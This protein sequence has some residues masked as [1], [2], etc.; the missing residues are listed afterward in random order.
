M[1]NLKESL[2]LEQLFL[3]VCRRGDK[4][5][6][7]AALEK[8]SLFDVNCVDAD[9]KSALVIAVESAQTDVVELLA[10]HPAIKH[11][12]ALLRAVDNH[13]LPEVKVLCESLKHRNLLLSGLYC[14]ASNSDFHPYVTPV[15]LAAHYNNYDILKLLTIEYGARVPNPSDLASPKDESTL[16]HSVGSLQLYKA[17]T[18]EVYMSLTQED[19]IEYAFKLCHKMRQLSMLNF[20]FRFEYEEFADKCETYAADI[21]GSVQ[22]TEEQTV[23]LTHQS[24]YS[25]SGSINGHNMTTDDELVVPYKVKRAIDYDQKK[26]VAHAHCQHRLVE[27]WYKGL[28]NWRNQ[29]SMK[30]LIFSLIMMFFYPV[31]SICYIL[32]PSARPGNLLKIPYVKFLCSVAS[33]LTFLLLLCLQSFQLRYT[34][35]ELFLI[36][37]SDEKPVTT[38]AEQFLFS[39]V[40]IQIVLFIVA[41]TWK[42]IRELQV[43][44]YRVLKYN[45]QGKLYDYFNLTLYWVWLMLR[46]SLVIQIYLGKPDTSSVLGERNNDTTVSEFDVGTCPTTW[47]SED[48]SCL[49]SKL[50][51]VMQQQENLNTNITAVIKDLEEKLQLQGGGDD[52][53]TVARRRK[54]SNVAA[55]LMGS[56]AS[57]DHSP[58]FELT[59]LQQFSV[60]QTVI[61]GEALIA[62]AKTMSFL[63]LVRITV[64]HILV[65]PM[66]IS[67]GRMGTDIIKFLS[68]FIL[69]LMAFSVGM[70]QVYHFGSYMSMVQSCL[71][72]GEPSCADQSESVTGVLQS[73]T[74]LFWTLFGL[75]DMSSFRNSDDEHWFTDL[76]GYMLFALYNS[77]AIIVLLNILIAMMSNTYTRIEEDA[78]THWKYSRSTLWISFYDSSAAL[79]PPFNILPSIESLRNCKRKRAFAKAKKNGIKTVDSKG[80]TY[81]TLMKELGHRYIFSKIK[82]DDDKPDPL[83]MQLKRDLSGLRSETKET[84]SGMGNVMKELAGEEVEEEETEMERMLNRAEQYGPIGMRSFKDPANVCDATSDCLPYVDDSAHSTPRRVQNHVNPA[85]IV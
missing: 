65:G 79:A 49:N 4:K 27:V 72:S 55:R 16:E 12:D 3:S 69:V 22:S 83:I 35:V 38:S 68:I 13:L 48:L 33:M 2:V 74:A 43:G 40:E 76:M 56:S 71:D 54:R 77:V 81:A 6:I 10:Y 14:R 9:G 52:G 62:L 42:H 36:G 58:S 11:G 70:H 15:V 18:S 7:L 50:D 85:T 17:L 63:S 80:V 64:V 61:F 78:D 32:H 20:E 47:E 82:E 25:G 59:E 21:L 75:S 39:I 24:D 28:T 5:E 45:A 19:P 46:I 51:H 30:S 53:I 60:V 26:F 84:L 1:S 37:L 23:V 44:G 67:F 29:G 66:Q 41:Y 8:R 57:L 34:L 31:I 73:V